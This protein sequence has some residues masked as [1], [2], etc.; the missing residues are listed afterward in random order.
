MTEQKNNGTFWKTV[1]ELIEKGN[2]NNFSIYRKGKK[3]FSISITAFL[4]LLILF[5]PA[6]LVA[7]VVGLFLGC[8]YHFSGPDFP[9]NNQLNQFFTKLTEGAEINKE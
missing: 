1:Q 6:V 4:L 3:A 9:E 5:C 2:R 7:M 8:R